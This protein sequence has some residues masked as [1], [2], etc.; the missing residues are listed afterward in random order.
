MTS[1]VQELKDIMGD[2]HSVAKQVAHLWDT[3]QSQRREWLAQKQEL[4]AYVTATDTTTTSNNKNGWKN[5]TTLP[6]LCQIRDNLHANYLSG[7]LPNDDWM[8]WEAYTQ[9][10]SERR[11]RDAIQAYMSNKMRESGVREVLS[12]L[13][14][15]YID[16]GNA[17]SDVEYVVDVVADTEGEEI[18]RYVGPRIIRIAPEDIV[19]N[20]LAASINH[21]PKIVR[22]IRTVA[23][24]KKQAGDKYCPEHIKVAAA[25]CENR[26]K[27][28]EFKTDD[29]EKG[30]G[31][32][33][34][35]FGD[36][37]EYFRSGI[38]EFLEL[39]GDLYDQETGISYPGH[40]ITVMDRMHVVRCEPV[41]SWQ[42]STIRHVGWRKRSDNLW[43]M[44]PLDNLVGMQYRIDHLENIKADLFDLTAFPPIAVKGDVQ[45]FVWQP[46]E[47]I[48]L[49][50]DG[51]LD[52][53]RIE[54][55][56][57][58]ADNQ[59]AYLQQQMEQFAG[60][61]QEAMG[62]RSPGE[63]TMYEI[64][65]LMTGAGRIFQEK[66]T[67]FEVCILEPSLNDCLEIARRV[68][69]FE[70][71]VR[72]MDDDL[73]AVV[74]M[75]ITKAD[76]TAKGKLRAV[77]ARHFSAK[78]QTMQNLLGVVNS[79]LWAEIRQHVSKFELAKLIEDGLQLS[80]LGL[81]Q[82]DAGLYEDAQTQMTISE[83]QQE[84]A[85]QQ[86]TNLEEPV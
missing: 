60:A 23:D 29:F 79:P 36:I 69:S 26:S 77:G 68:G 21:T 8:Q 35:K 66:I 19:F 61:P 2:R 25:R 47:K 81:V 39:Q 75:N 84:M 27:L 49:G 9:D 5:R 31:L 41:P 82:K 57:L 10:G 58:S 16:Y 55:A 18:V 64:Q 56:A 54:G 24:I 70:D 65:Q 13:L 45:E 86:Q 74:F 32:K 43:A 62:I 51:S 14:Y 48:F 12:Q 3:Y 22:S 1:R 80:R 20:P 53:V 52:V 40:I 15:D 76:I 78:S 30:Y 17:F 11:K 28:G 63:K 73:G 85:I 4:R 6:K 59:I 67:T 72:V 7:L 42:G 33:I 83:I 37:S 44:G 38:V 34:D 71:V 46:G 50:E